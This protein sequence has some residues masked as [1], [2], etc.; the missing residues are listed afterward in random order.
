[1][2]RNLTYRR[3]FPTAKYIPKTLTL[4]PNCKDDFVDILKK[5]LN[6]QI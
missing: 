6:N 2:H 4:H 5:R 1:M 3:K